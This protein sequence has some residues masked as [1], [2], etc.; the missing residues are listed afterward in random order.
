[1]CLHINLK[2]VRTEIRVNTDG[3]GDFEEK[4]YIYVCEICKEEFSVNR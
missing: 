4:V 2:Y 3:G 1:M